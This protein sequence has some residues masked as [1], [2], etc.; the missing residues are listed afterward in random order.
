MKGTY[1]RHHC[2]LSWHSLSCV[3]AGRDMSWFSFSR[4]LQENL[5][6]SHP[7]GGALGEC[8]PITVVLLHLLMMI[9]VRQLWQFWQERPE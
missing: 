5:I 3:L 8:E 7:H 1:R 6:A 2:L 9:Q 4:I